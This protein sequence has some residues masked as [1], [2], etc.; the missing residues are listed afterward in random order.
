MKFRHYLETI[1]GVDIYP[2]ISLL[3]FFIFFLALLVYLYRTD[4][5]SVFQMKSIPLDNETDTPQTT[6]NVPS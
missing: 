2:L 1:A 3:I 5:K 6:H 4:K